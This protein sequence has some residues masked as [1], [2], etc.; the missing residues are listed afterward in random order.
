MMMEQN[1]KSKKQTQEPMQQRVR[2]LYETKNKS[3][4]QKF[5]EDALKYECSFSFFFFAKGFKVAYP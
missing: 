5:A 2:S 4:F 1:P 3:F